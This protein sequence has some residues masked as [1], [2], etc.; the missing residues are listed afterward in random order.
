MLNDKFNK[1]VYLIDIHT[2]TIASGHAYSTLGEMVAAAQRKQLSIFGITEHTPKMPGTCHP[3]YF[4]NFG[5]VPRVY[6]S[7]RLLLGAELNILDYEGH[8][9]LDEIYL[10]ELDLRIAGIHKLCYQDGTKSQNTDAFVG[11]MEN[12]WIQIISHPA[13]GTA[14]QVD[15]EKVVTTAK[16]TGTI[17]ELNNSSLNPQRGKKLAKNYNTELLQLCK[18]HD[19]PII[20][21]SDAHHESL[22]AFFDYAKQLIHETG[23]PDELIIN[24]YPDLFIQLLKTAPETHH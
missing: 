12:P 20:V 24:R 1:D 15:F 11:A 2:H 4:K 7:M 5:V 23:F 18:R 10:K 22:V 6:G 13:D 14:S 8:I 9:D 3:V 16:Q 19:V 17:L 21:S